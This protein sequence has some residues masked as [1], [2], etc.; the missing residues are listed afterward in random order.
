MVKWWLLY[1][2]N[3]MDDCAVEAEMLSAKM[4]SLSLAPVATVIF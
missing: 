2:D 4:L 1:A 3:V